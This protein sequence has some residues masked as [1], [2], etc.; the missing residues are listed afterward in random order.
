MATGVRE[1]EQVD[2]T[3]VGA[4]PVGLYG[5]YSA[6]LHGLT[7]RIFDRLPT[8]GGQLTALYPEKQVYDVA[9]F[10]E[11]AA[12]E[13]VSRL[14]RQ[15]DQF[16]HDYRLGEEL[17]N[18]VRDEDRDGWWV[19]TERGRYPTRRVVITAGIG[20][21]SPRRLGIPEVEAAEGRGVHYVVGPLHSFVGHRVLVIGGGNSAAD[22][23]LNL[24]GKAKRVGVVH[25]RASLQCHRDSAQKL[26]RPGA[27]DLYWEQ[28]V[29]GVRMAYDRVSA[30]RLRHVRTGE[31]RWVETDDVVVAI[32]LVSDLGP[33]AHIGLDLVGGE[34]PVRTTGETNLPG[35][36]AAGDVATYPGKVKLIATGFGEVATA[37]YHAAATLAAAR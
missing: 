29:T 2:I 6:G 23:A 13:L 18:L 7:A 35:V 22:W 32:G 4:G 20:H 16:G 5:M 9:G 14:A 17:I 26:N 28:E 10:P 24:K 21:F 1:P 33:L 15:A 25:R 31:E 36:Y 34:V 3:M 8:R 12:Y 37:V 27:F 30:A 11:V 19:E